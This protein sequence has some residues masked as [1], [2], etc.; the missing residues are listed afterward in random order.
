MT[1]KKIGKSFKYCDICKRKNVFLGDFQ[2]KPF[3][4]KNFQL[5]RLSQPKYKGKRRYWLKLAG[6]IYLHQKH[7]QYLSLFKD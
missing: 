6:E 7:H 4:A 3:L 2:P 1:P 5:D